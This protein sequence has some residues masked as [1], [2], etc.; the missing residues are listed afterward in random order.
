MDPIQTAKPRLRQG[1]THYFNPIQ[2]PL[3]KPPRPRRH[4][5][6]DDAAEQLL[7][8]QFLLHAFL[9]LA[10][11]R[12]G[13]LHACP[14][15]FAEQLFRQRQHQGF[16][17]VHMAQ[18]EVAE[19]LHGGGKSD[20]LALAAGLKTQQRLLQAGH[21]RCDARVIA[22]QLVD[23]P[24]AAAAARVQ[25][26]QQESVFL[27]MMQPRGI[28]VEVVEHRAQ[29]VEIGPAAAVVAVARHQIAHGVHH[30][31]QAAMLIPDHV[32]RVFHGASLVARIVGTRRWRRLTLIKRAPFFRLRLD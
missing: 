26:L 28:S 16:L 14:V 22:L 32:Q 6:S 2:P 20:E 12:A 1:S 11:Q 27:R 29:V 18:I 3:R 23:D 10:R 15:R 19:S 4:S 25:R 30:R 5:R 31:A 7:Q 8:L 21:R 13:R 17:P 9:R 24:V